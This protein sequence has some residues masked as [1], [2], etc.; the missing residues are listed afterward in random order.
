MQKWLIWLRARLAICRRTASGVGVGVQTLEGGPFARLMTKDTEQANLCLAV[1]ALPY[2]HPQRYVL[3][4]L[5]TV[6]GGG[7]SSRLFQEI[8]EKRGLAYT[9]SSTPRNCRIPA[10]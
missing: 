4:L 7:M 10:R 9:V 3:A 6:L 2:D 1:P 8:R 5:D